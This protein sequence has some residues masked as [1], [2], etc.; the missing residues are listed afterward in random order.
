MC[1]MNIGLKLR[2]QPNELCN[3]EI[4]VGYALTERLNYYLARTEV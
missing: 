2:A 3:I 4:K 1:N